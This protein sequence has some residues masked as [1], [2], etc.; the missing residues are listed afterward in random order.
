MRLLGTQEK[1]EIEDFDTQ[2]KFEIEDF[3][4]SSKTE[5]SERCL[6]E[7]SSVAFRHNQS[8]TH[9]MWRKCRKSER[10][11]KRIQQVSIDD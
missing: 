7:K 9:H 8:K 1:F 6:W 10:K 11:F 2:E 5:R 3:S 4:G